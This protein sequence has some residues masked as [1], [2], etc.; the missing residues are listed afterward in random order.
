MKMQTPQVSQR[1]VAGI[2]R[3]WFFSLILLF[4]ISHLDAQC[5]LICNDNVFV[6]LGPDGFAVVDAD[7]VLE[8]INQQCPGTKYVN[9]YVNN[10][11]I[12][13]TVTCVHL[14]MTLDVWVRD[15]ASNDSIECSITVEDKMGPMIM[16]EDTT[17]LCGVQTDSFAMP[18][19]MDNCDP[20]PESWYFDNR[21]NLTCTGGPFNEIIARSWYA[22][23]NLNNL[24]VS[25]IQRIYLKTPSLSDVVFPPNYDGITLPVLDCSTPSV[26]SSV[27]GVPVIDSVSIGLACKFQVSHEDT[28]LPICENGFKVIREW[29][30]LDCCSGEDTSAF[31]IIKVMDTT[32]PVIICPDTIRVGT[33]P[34]LCETSLRAPA[35]TVSDDCSS[36]SNIDVRIFYPGGTIIGNGGII[37]SL[38][39][40]FHTITY[41]ATDDCGNRSTC[42]AVVQVIDNDPPV[43]VCVEFL[44][45]NINSTGMGCIPATSFDAGSYDNCALD[46]ILVKRMGEPDSLFRDRVCFFCADVGNA[47]MVVVRFIDESGNI[48]ECMT[49]V[50]PQDKL[51]PSIICPADTTILCTQD[52]RDTLLTGVAFGNDNCGIPVIS[53]VDDTTMLSMCGTGMVFRTF[54]ATDGGGRTASCTQKITIIDTTATTFTPAADVTVFCPVDLDTLT[55]GVPTFMADCE[56]WGLS[57]SDTTFQSGC[58]RIVRRSYT[59]YEWCSQ[60]D[61]VFSQEITIIDNDPPDWLNATGSLDTTL[62]CS[63]QVNTLIP[64]ADDMC[65]NATVRL[66]RND[67][68]PGSCINDYQLIRAYVAEDDCGNV[69]DTFFVNAIVRDTTP[70]EFLNFP[71]DLS[72]ECGD[73]FNVPTIMATDNCT[74][75]FIS[76][77]PV[78]DTLP[79]ACPI[80]EIYRYRWIIVDNCN[81]RDTGFWDVNLVDITAPTANPI[82][83]ST[84][85]CLDDVPGPDTAVVT[86]EMDNCGGPVLVSYVRD[87]IQNTCE[88]TLFRFYAIS[89]TCGNAVNIVQRYFIADR[90]PPRV[91]SCPGM[92]T[93]TIITSPGVCEAFIDDLMATYLDNCSGPITVTNN[94]PFADNPNSDDASGMYPLGR[95]IFNFFGVDTCG[96]VNDLCIVDLTVTELQ[97][98]SLDCVTDD[99]ILNLDASGNAVLDST[100]VLNSI[101]VDDCS[102]VTVDILPN[103]FNCDSLLAGN[104]KMVTVFATD[105]FGNVA[106]CGPLTVVLQDPLRVCNNPLGPPGNLGGFVKTV[107]GEVLK[108]TQLILQGDKN[109][110]LMIPSSGNYMFSGMERGDNLVLKAVNDEDPLNGVSTFDI[111]LIAKHILGREFIDSPEKMIAADVNKSGTITVLDIVE[112]RKMI[113]GKQI[114]FSN[115]H[116]WRTWNA[117]HRF[118]QPSNPFMTP[119]PEYIIFTNL[120]HSYYDLNFVAV[121]TGDVNGDYDLNFNGAVLNNRNKSFAE[122]NI[123]EEKIEPG[124]KVEIDFYL[125][126]NFKTDGIQFALDF[127]ETKLEL[128]DILTAENISE[129][130]HFGF[131]KIES[132]I[133]KFS[134]NGTKNIGSRLFTAVFE[135][136]STDFLSKSIALSSLELRNEVYTEEGNFDLA[137]KF[138]DSGFDNITGGSIEFYNEP[139]PFKGQTIVK[140]LSPK[141]MNSQMDIVGLDGRLIKSEQL[142]LQEG[143]NSFVVKGS[144]LEI[145]GVYWC[146]LKTPDGIKTIK[147]VYVK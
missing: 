60:M 120:A 90:I 66:V 51:P 122:I 38:D 85:A 57:I 123:N 67:S 124:K 82:P 50:W 43:P 89:D 34:D 115:N 23:D 116:S 77:S 92:R 119:L 105:T 146:R 86:G 25:C 56:N 11:P 9:V 27:T 24:A 26:D 80:L 118:I 84:Y 70:P 108:N 100:M 6:S 4:P 10:Q 1:S 49:E 109:E 128:K 40:G 61:T 97:P 17:V 33:L 147:M 14:G 64:M 129:R 36:P 132:G 104:I 111:V 5:T 113:L 18:I 42:E 65:N 29:T 83:D 3:L 68:I 112:I 55:I 131:T 73:T 46:T 20:N 88:D 52:F 138:T 28:Y 91:Q 75:N 30:V 133:I 19:I 44:G 8:N 78:V 121:K 140:I 110:T 7:M 96:N 53:F 102:S 99:I 125:P 145:P 16:C 134:W 58:D 130:E 144:D 87:E 127:D 59:F 103:S 114:G 72:I 79:G 71:A 81:N 117:T 137:L 98:P 54:T 107:N 95:H 101:P 22:R 35:A 141:E 47:I 63:G 48:N 76:D 74:G 41:E 126:D 62:Q 94:S 31:Q 32:P 139:N 142:I 15:S 93:D 143:I 37:P 13:D 106:T 21:M 69:S 2:L 39:L 12:G 45:V 136:K 135:G